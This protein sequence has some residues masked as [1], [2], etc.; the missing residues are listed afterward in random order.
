[1]APFLKTGSLICREVKYS[2]GSVKSEVNK[3]GKHYWLKWDKNW[4]N[5]NFKINSFYHMSH[6]PDNQVRQSL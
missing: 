6:S 4:C 3:L 5:H 1:M 2:T